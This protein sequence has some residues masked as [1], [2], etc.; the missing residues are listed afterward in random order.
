M[1]GDEWLCLEL[2][3]ELFQAAFFCYNG[4]CTVSRRIILWWWQTRKDGGG[5]RDG[6]AGDVCECGCAWESP[7]ALQWC[8]FVTVRL[9]YVDIMCVC[10][11]DFDKPTWEQISLV[12][13][14]SPA[15]PPLHSLSAVKPP[16]FIFKLC[17]CRNTQF[18]ITCDHKLI[19]CFGG[20][21]SRTARDG[22]GRTRHGGYV[23]MLFFQDG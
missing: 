15:L 4:R 6:G 1:E 19:K 2:R 9:L 22:H 23:E 12:H 18:K 21:S 20:G 3:G 7:H 10:V 14:H 5:V 17:S 8:S 16:Q 11:C 13:L